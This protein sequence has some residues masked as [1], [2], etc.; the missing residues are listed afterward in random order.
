MTHR[1]IVLQYRYIDTDKQV[2]FRHGRY[3]SKRHS[4]FAA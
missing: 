4:G 2:E 1:L 3:R